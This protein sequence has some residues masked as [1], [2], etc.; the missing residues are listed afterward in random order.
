MCKECVIKA[1][2]N[3][4]GTAN[5]EKVYLIMRQLDNFSKQPDHFLAYF[6]FLIVQIIYFFVLICFT[7]RTSNSI[8]QEPKIFK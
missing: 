1:C 8:I 6:K 4:D 2:A 3:E 7:P 5:D